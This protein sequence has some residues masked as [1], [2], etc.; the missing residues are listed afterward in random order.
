MSLGG[1]NEDNFINKTE[2]VQHV[3]SVDNELDVFENH[4]KTS[5]KIRN[6]ALHTI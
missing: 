2:S 3:Y 5:S 4:W 1:F 6:K